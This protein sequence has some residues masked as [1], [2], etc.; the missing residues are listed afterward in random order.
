MKKQSIF[1][2]TRDIIPVLYSNTAFTPRIAYLTI[3]R[4]IFNHTA[5]CNLNLTERDILES[6]NQKY[7]KAYTGEGVYPV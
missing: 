1:D 6:L 3:D 7:Y 4:L 2:A 5:E